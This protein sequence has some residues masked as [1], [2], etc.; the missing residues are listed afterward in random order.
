[1]GVDEIQGALRVS[2]GQETS[3]QDLELF[4]SALEGIAARRAGGSRAA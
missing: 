1:M 3:A 4:R 2:I